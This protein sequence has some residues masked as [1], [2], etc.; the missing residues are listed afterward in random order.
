MND[1]SSRIMRLKMKLEEFDYTIV[2]VYD[3]E[4]SK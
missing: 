2:Y 4:N 3:K 1:P